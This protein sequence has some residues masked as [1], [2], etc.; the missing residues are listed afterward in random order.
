MLQALILL[1][2]IPFLAGLLAIMVYVAFIKAI[3]TGLFKK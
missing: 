2:A 3:L 1:L